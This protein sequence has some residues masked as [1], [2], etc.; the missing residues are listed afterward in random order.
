MIV[1]SYASYDESELDRY[2]PRVVH[3]DR[4]NRILDVDAEVATLLIAASA[5]L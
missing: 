5:R 3:V 1:I 4:G 2:E